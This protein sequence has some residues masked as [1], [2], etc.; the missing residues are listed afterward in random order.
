[1]KG[2]E[3]MI[4]SAEYAEKVRIKRAKLNL[5]KTELSKKLDVSRQ[6]ISKIEVGNYK[7]PRRIYQSVMEWLVDD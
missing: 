1:M 3:N 4:I 6:T 2:G 5:T 7:A